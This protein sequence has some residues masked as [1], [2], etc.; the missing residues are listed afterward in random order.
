[1]PG[2]DSGTAEELAGQYEFTGGN[3]ENISRKSTVEY[4]LTGNRPSAGQVKAFC[5]EENWSRNKNKIGF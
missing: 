2:L 5:E 4:V 1:M 3:I